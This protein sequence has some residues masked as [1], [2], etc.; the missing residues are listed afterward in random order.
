MNGFLPPCGELL[1]AAQ[2]WAVSAEVSSLRLSALDPSP[3]TRSVEPAPA[4]PLAY[5]ASG[6]PRRRRRPRR[7]TV[8]VALLGR[9]YDVR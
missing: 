2:R 9:Q 7:R 6:H 5:G 4:D 3:I 8:R 1:A